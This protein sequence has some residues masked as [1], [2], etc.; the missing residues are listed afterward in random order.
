MTWYEFF[1]LC[2]EL[3]LEPEKVLVNN[4]DIRKLSEDEAITYLSNP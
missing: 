2:G 3:K 1:C 4:P